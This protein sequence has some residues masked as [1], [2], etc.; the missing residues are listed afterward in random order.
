MPDA[1]PTLPGCFTCLHLHQG[2]ESWEMPHIAWYECAFRPANEGLKGFPWKH[3][4]CKGHTPGREPLQG[5][6]DA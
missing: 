3:T 5:E 4:I 6:P 1:R 2:T